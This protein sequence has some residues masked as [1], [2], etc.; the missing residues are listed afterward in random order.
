MIPQK[1]QLFLSSVR[2]LAVLGKNAHIYGLGITRSGVSNR[3]KKMMDWTVIFFGLG[4]LSHG[5]D[6]KVPHLI[7]VGI[8][9]QR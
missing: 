3:P 2:I 4:E 6:R 7:L 5:T 8:R 9:R 1:W